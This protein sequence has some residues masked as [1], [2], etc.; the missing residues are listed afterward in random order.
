VLTFLGA[1]IV[2]STFIVKEGMREHLKDL[3]DSINA[4][5]SEYLIRSDTTQANGMLHD[6]LLRLES[7]QS[8]SSIL[9]S[10]SDQNGAANLRLDVLLYAMLRIQT[11]HD[12]IGDLLDK[13]PHQEFAKIQ[14]KELKG[15]FAELSYLEN[16]LLSRKVNPEWQKVLDEF[17]ARM[18][19]LSVGDAPI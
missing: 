2:F 17:N 14:L 8:S 9:G 13:L 15:H 7:L 11:V 10:S 19:E 6:I 18:T 5:Q 16:R 3:S 12:N 4:A 1:V